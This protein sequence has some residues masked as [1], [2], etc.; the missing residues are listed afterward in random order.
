M[1]QRSSNT[2]LATSGAFFRRLR[3]SGTTTGTTETA[4]SEKGFQNLGGR[5]I[6]SVLTTGGDGYGQPGPSSQA[7][8]G[9]SGTQAGLGLGTTSSVTGGAPP[10]PSSSAGPGI[11]TGVMAAAG[12]TGAAVGTHERPQ[13][14]SPGPS[15]SGLSDT[16]FYRASQGFYGGTA[17]DPSSTSPG[18]SPPGPSAF[19]Q[20]PGPGEVNYRPGPA[21]QT[22]INQPGFAPLRPP[23]GRGTPPPGRGRG[24]PPP[25]RALTPQMR[26]EVGRSHP[27][28]DGS[29]GSRFTE[30]V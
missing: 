28:F 11:S 29:R 3:S 24:T 17:D 7:P 30:E 13:E 21:R 27:S 4:P 15:D 25:P 1:T 18:S 10:P 16:S 22:I 26:D 19:P 12:A 5:K 8:R 2:P 20:P 14:T 23:A 6:E 9:Y